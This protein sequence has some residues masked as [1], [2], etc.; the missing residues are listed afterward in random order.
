[1][2]V[3]QSEKQSGEKR[4]E[5]LAQSDSQSGPERKNSVPQ[6]EKQ[7]TLGLGKNILSVLQSEKQSSAVY[8]VPRCDVALR[9]ILCFVVKYW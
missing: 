6:S 4:L 5:D 1:M 9:H 7:C 3:Q 8:T 2:S